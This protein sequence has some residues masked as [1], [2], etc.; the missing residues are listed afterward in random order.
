MSCILLGD[1]ASFSRLNIPLFLERVSAGFP[2][3]AE[4]YVE[5]TLDLNELCIQHPASTFFVR[6]QG[7]SMVEAGIL[8]EDVLVVD[9]SLRAKHG[10]IIIASLESEMTVKQL[11][12]T[13]PPVRLLPRNPAYQPMIIDADMVLE[14]FGVVT[15][16]VRSLK[17]GVSP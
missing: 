6:V 15:N 17:R 16:V 1:Y 9:R 10:D 8:P 12:L 13:P 7:E 4:D 2:S 5:K 11:H 3:P 14:V